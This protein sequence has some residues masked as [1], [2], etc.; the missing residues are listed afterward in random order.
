MHGIYINI[1]IEVFL[2]MY[3]KMIFHQFF[4]EKRDH[5]YPL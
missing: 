2:K 5:K 3:R 4:E 1:I